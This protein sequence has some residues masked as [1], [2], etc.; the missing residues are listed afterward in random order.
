[1]RTKSKL[2]V[3]VIAKQAGVSPATVSRVMNKTP[4]VDLATRKKV[5]DV[6]ERVDYKPRQIRNRT[7]H[8]G[9]LFLMEFPIID[10]YAASIL[11]GVMGYCAEM[12]LEL[13]VIQ[14]TPQQ[15]NA[16][17]DLVKM[18]LE[19]GCDAALG[20]CASEYLE[21]LQEIHEAGLPVV[22]IGNRSDSYDFGYVDADNLTGTMDAMDFL[23]SCGHRHI[24]LF[25]A[26]MKSE[27]HLARLQAYKQKLL[28]F[29]LEIDEKLIVPLIPI[30]NSMRAGQR[31][32]EKF[33][34]DGLRA[35]AIMCMAEE[36]AY[37]AIRA[38]NDAGLNVP[39]DMSIVGFDGHSISEFISPPLTTIRQPLARMGRRATEM[40]LA[41]INSHTNKTGKEIMATE[42]IV[43]QSVKP[44]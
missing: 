39:A 44:V 13:S 6:V 30:P 5:L 36:L 20:L 10:H 35:T 40:V 16:G 28:E 18:L 26:T 27:D 9:L 21:R 15:L 43:R 37:G 22:T 3:N 38:L 11:E 4:N 19:R 32:M 1:M 34:Q 29:N 14:I 33:H 17:E 42:L 24:A 25:C 12:G 31:M 2:S 41:A 8:I 23:L 7:K